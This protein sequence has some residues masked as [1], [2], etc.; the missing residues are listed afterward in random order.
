MIP[1][2]GA[3]SQ[4]VKIEDT[5]ICKQDDP[6]TNLRFW[7]VGCFESSTKLE[8]FKPINKM[9]KYPRT[10]LPRFPEDVDIICN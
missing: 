8:E 1:G 10:G 7:I 2:N 4:T 3:Q 9:E 6:D 5:E